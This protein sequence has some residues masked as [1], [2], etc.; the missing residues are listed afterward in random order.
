VNAQSNQND[1]G[2]EVDAT[3]DIAEANLKQRGITN[4]TQQQLND[5]IDNVEMVRGMSKVPAGEMPPN[6]RYGGKTGGVYLPKAKMG[7]NDVAKF[8]PLYEYDVDYGAMADVLYEGGAQFNEFLE[9]M[10][11]VMSPE[12]E[13]AMNSTDRKFLPAGYDSTLQG[14]IDKQTGKDFTDNKSGGRLAG[15]S[16]DPIDGEGGQMFTKDFMGRSRKNGGIAMAKAG[17]QVGEELTLT[18]GQLKMME[19]LGFKVTQLY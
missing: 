19:N 6:F 14:Q 10:N 9:K 17:L 5:A 4:P 13:R 7:N 2:N 12:E 16:G 3:Y 15:R 1:Y 8:K 18:P 11:T